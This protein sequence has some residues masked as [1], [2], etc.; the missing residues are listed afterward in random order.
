MLKK[1]LYLLLLFLSVFSYAQLS[2]KEIDSLYTKTKGK[3]RN[4]NIEEVIQ[5]IN[6]TLKSSKL[7]VDYNLKTRFILCQLYQFQGNISQSIK[8]ADQAQQYAAK[9]KDFLWQARFLGFISSEYRTTN[10]NALSQKKILEAIRAAE[11]APESDELFSF[12]QN[13]Y[14]EMAFQAIFKKDFD[15]AHSYLK[16]GVIYI[17]KI[18]NLSLQSY[19]LA[20]N[21]E[22]RSVLY[23]F[24][25]KSDSAIYYADKALQIIDTQ[26]SDINIKMLQNYIYNDLGKAYLDKKD[27]ASS[28]KYFSK[29]FNDSNAYRTPLLNREIY[30]HIIT[31]YKN[32]ENL[33]NIRGNQKKLDSISTQISQTDINI[34]ND[35]IGKLQIEK[36]HLQR[37]KSYCWYAVIAFVTIIITFSIRIWRK[38]RNSKTKLIVKQKTEQKLIKDDDKIKADLN[39]AKETEQRLEEFI[40]KFE[41]QKQFLDSNISVSV[42]A[43]QSCTNTKYISHILRKMYNKDFTTYINHLRIDYIVNLLENE[44]KYRHYKISYLA[45]IAG[46]SSHSKFTSIFKKIKGFPPFEFINN[47]E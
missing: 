35:T 25:Q 36:K 16:Q 9:Q 13:A 39:I 28:K 10:M 2:T 46:Y 42:L 40:K 41:K 24:Q 3:S 29:V 30:N 33:D 11:K 34:M 21:Y 37:Q 47:L 23:N 14:L 15:K 32:R 1:L 45:E 12:Q 19:S 5:D 22:Y 26:K 8:T 44:P 18:D 43:N 38:K 31:Y 17:D 7:S 6:Q 20:I 27:L 4:I